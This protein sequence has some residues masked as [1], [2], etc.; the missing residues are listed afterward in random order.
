MA[1][2]K[3]IKAGAADEPV[4]DPDAGKHCLPEPELEEEGREEFESDVEDDETTDVQI[5]FTEKD[6]ADFVLIEKQVESGGRQEAEAMR[7]IRKR[8]LWRLAVDSDDKPI[9]YANFKEYCEERWGHTPQWVTHQTNWLAITEEMERLGITDPPHLS[10]RAAQGLSGRLKDAGGLRTVLEEAKQ[11]GLP[12]DR[13]SLREIVLR[14]ANY[15]YYSKEGTPGETKPAAQTYAAYKLDVATAKQLGEAGSYGLVTEALKANG[16]QHGIG[17]ADQIVLLSQ[18]K[19]KMPERDQL[20]AN[21]TGVALE[22]LVE[23]LK[24]VAQEIKTI[25]EKKKLLEQHKQEIKFLQGGKV[26]QLKSEAKA[27][28]S[29]LVEK[30][31]IK[32]KGKKQEKPQDDGRGIP[33]IFDPGD[34]DHDDQGASE[35]LSNLIDALGSLEFAQESEWPDESEELKRILATTQDCE[36]LLAE[37]NAKVKE[38][39]AEVDEPEFVPSGE[40]I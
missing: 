27:L 17:F 40:A 7:E 3:R 1:T 26:K 12:M 10:V 32:K 13:D 37:I 28:E 24:D 18:Q 20:L 14:R 15:N 4:G 36:A 39:L 22:E 2:K 11:D 9:L 8:Q 34:D 23:R 38:S 19:R 21:F 6:K 25:Q 30:G 33:E 16:G 29:E 5:A 31:A 35:V